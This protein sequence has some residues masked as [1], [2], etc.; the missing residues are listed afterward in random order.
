MGEGS[1][2]SRYDGLRASPSRPSTQGISEPLEP[3]DR[4]MA[5]G[6]SPT[7]G[8]T[9]RNRC[10]ADIRLEFFRINARRQLP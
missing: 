8:A 7:H 6:E 10:H 9:G 3:S 5:V 2:S 1:F 4:L